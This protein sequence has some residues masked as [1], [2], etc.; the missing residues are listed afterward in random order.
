MG[1]ARIWGEV[2][3]MPYGIQQI[4]H[5]VLTRTVV[6]IVAGISEVE[7]PT[8]LMGFPFNCQNFRC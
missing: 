8:N 5:V 1:R 6:C 2:K 4:Q 3:L 7:Y